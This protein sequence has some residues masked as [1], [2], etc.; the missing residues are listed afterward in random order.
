MNFLNYTWETLKEAYYSAFDLI[1][2]NLLWAVFTLLI[3]TAPP[4]FAGLYYVAH[5]LTHEELISPRTFLEGF[6]TYF[7]LSWRWFLVFIGMLGLLLINFWFYRNIDT[8]WAPWMQ[9]FFLGLMILWLLI[10]LYSFPILLEQSDKSV[11]LALKN[12]LVVFMRTPGTSLSLVLFLLVLAILS[13]I[14][15]IPWLLFT[16]SLSAYLITR[17]L[18]QSIEQIQNT[19]K[20]NQL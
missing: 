7:W 3:V 14:L 12:S 13:T 1:A 8:A 16:P 17:F 9:G 6:R 10:N 18:F 2:A 19:T 4:A 11:R 5:Q 20:N 15:Q